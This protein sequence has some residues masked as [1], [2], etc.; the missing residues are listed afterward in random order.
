[1]LSNKQRWDK[2]YSE[3]VKVEDGII[4]YLTG[5]GWDLLERPEGKHPEWDIKVGNDKGRVETIEIKG[6]YTVYPNVV[7]EFWHNGKPSGIATSKADWYMIYFVKT[8]ELFTVKRSQVLEMFM[9][10]PELWTLRKVNN[11]S[12]EIET[13]TYGLSKENIKRIAFY[14]KVEI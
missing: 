8:N 6:D 10:H 11:P 14:K 1:M 9:T 2:N 12:T 5:K 7:F 13:L 4:N 3:G